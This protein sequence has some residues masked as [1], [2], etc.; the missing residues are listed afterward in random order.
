[1]T[2]CTSCGQSNAPDAQFCVECGEYLGWSSGG[3]AAVETATEDWFDEPAPRATPAPPAPAAPAPAPPAAAPAPTPTAPPAP[4]PTAPRPPTPVAPRPPTPAAPPAPPARTPD[5][6]SAPPHR[7]PVEQER[8]VPGPPVERGRSQP[9]SPRRVP[10][11]AAPR[12]RDI[13]PTAPPTPTAPQGPPRNATPQRPAPA[14]PQ[15]PAAPRSASPPRA[16]PTAP[17]SDLARVARALDEGRKLAERHDRPDLGNHLELARKRLGEQVLSVAVVGEFKR[18]K[19]TLVNALLQ[20]DVCPTD[21]DIVTAVP[22]VVRYGAE[23]SAAAQLEPVDRPPADSPDDG[24]VE[25]PVDVDRLADLV[26]EA[27]DPSWRRRLRS[28]EVRLPHRLL[29]TGLSLVDTPGVGGLESAHGIVTLG[30]LRTTAGVIFVTD[31]SQELTGPEVDFLRQALERCSAAVCVVTKTDLYPAWRRIVELNR[32]HLAEAGIDLPMI[33]VSSFLRL[34][35]WRSPALNEESGFAPLF[36]WLRA[37]VLEAAAKQ[38]V[39]AAS[40]DLGFAQEQLRLEVSSEQQVLA[41][42]EASEE[43]VGAL[44]RRSERTR[45]LVERGNGWQQF[46]FDGIDQ[47]IADVK[48]DFAGRMRTVVRDVEAVIDQGDPKESWSDIEVW[49][50]RQVVRAANE[51]HELLNERAAALAADVAET[52]ALESDEPLQLGLTAPVDVLR[53]LTFDPAQPPPDSQKLVRMLFAGRAALIPATVAGSV[54]SAAGGL[55]LLAAAAPIILG[56]GFIGRKLIRDERQRQL[57]Y[58]RQQAKMS[59]RRYLDEANFV[60]EKDCLDSLRRTRRE[61]R[62]EF[63]ARAGVLHASSQRALSSAERAASLTPQQR[64]QRAAELAARRAEIERLGK[65]PAASRGAA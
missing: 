22:T 12:G 33:P 53:G 43:V 35:A 10:D 63:Q 60:I 46:L 37:A 20:T 11:P 38:A 26:S 17:P 4:T 57:T 45:K 62:D 48:H 31:A 47:L 34:R 40:R 54:A 15:P 14:R 28:V 1:M 9:A 24:T 64:D 32:Q 2:A 19:S 52:F 49:L 13:T 61:L 39:A 55:L 42:P 59:C 16:E 23:P 21:A 41:R 30:A 36:D 7:P 50:Q 65:A 6:A 56:V 27:A 5:A 3:P 29:K 25:E 51:N 8:P 18:G 58:R 44:R